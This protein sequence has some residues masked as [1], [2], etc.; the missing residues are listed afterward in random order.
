MKRKHTSQNF[1]QLLLVS[2]NPP[3]F[4]LFGPGQTIVPL[5]KLLRP[6]LSELPLLIGGPW[7]SN[8]PRTGLKIPKHAN[9]KGYH[10]YVGFRVEPRDATRLVAWYSD[11]FKVTYSV[12]FIMLLCMCLD[13][14]IH[15]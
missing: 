15:P 6:A 5:E 8:T 12:H 3:Q 4:R 9:Y 2:N 14:D 7:V 1:K 11:V 10:E 13:I